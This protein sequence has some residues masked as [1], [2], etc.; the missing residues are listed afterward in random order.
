MIR[1]RIITQW[2]V[3]ESGWPKF[4]WFLFLLKMNSESAIVVRENSSLPFILRGSYFKV[5]E[6]NGNKVTAQCTSCRKEVK[7]NA[8]STGNFLKH[9]RVRMN[10]LFVNPLR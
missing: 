1:S 9:L 6:R 2:I 8:H 10:T 3:N 7:G 4:K 5:I